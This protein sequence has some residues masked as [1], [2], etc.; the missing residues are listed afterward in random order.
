MNVSN[1]QLPVIFRTSVLQLHVVILET[2]ASSLIML[3]QKI[4]RKDLSYPLIE[5]AV[6]CSQMSD[7]VMKPKALEQEGSVLLPFL[8]KLPETSQVTV[9]N[10][11]LQGE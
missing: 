9:Q 4:S 5:P 2:E 3:I 8:K 6:F 1:K 11:G 10:S 7:Q